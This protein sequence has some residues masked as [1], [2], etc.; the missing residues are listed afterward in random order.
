LLVTEGPAIRVATNLELLFSNNTGPPF[1]SQLY[2]YVLS[3]ADLSDPTGD[4]RWRK[5]KP[6]RAAG[7]VCLP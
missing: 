5:Q 6:R 1:G 4:D 7:V 3:A 2:E